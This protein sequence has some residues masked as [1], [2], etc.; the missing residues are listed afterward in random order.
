M[1]GDGDGERGCADTGQDEGR[2]D[3]DGGGDGE[4]DEPPLLLTLPHSLLQY[5]ILPVDDLTYAS[6][7]LHTEWFAWA[8]DCGGPFL[9]WAR[10]KIQATSVCVGRWITSNNWA[11]ISSLSRSLF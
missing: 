11:V 9:V 7:Y 10:P 6:P 1:R 4:A 8:Y 3:N 2:R 5:T